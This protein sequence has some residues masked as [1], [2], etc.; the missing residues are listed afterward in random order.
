MIFGILYLASNFHAC[1]M[2]E[3]IRGIDQKGRLLWHDS[4]RDVFIKVQQVGAHMAAFAPQWHSLLG[5]CCVSCTLG[6]SHDGLRIT[7]STDSHTHLL[8]HQEYAPGL[9]DSSEQALVQRQFEPL[10]HPETKGFF[11]HLFP[12][13]KE[14]RGSVS[15]HRSLLLESPSGHSTVQDGNP[16]ISQVVHQRE[17]MD[18]VHWHTGRISA[19]LHGKSCT[20]ILPVLGQRLSV[21]IQL[22]HLPSI[23]YQG[24]QVA[25]RGQTPMLTWTIGFSAPHP[26]YRPELM[27]IWSCECCST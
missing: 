21:P 13:V 11:S 24:S 12:G 2:S 27:P 4:W 1:R 15:Y 16:G 7:T 25:P 9:L 18:Y 26:L 10:F 17:Q 14:D 3:R 19:H 20:E 6:D 8:Q 22:G 23:I 5:E